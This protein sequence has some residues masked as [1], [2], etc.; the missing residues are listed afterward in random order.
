MFRS[1]LDE[2]GTVTRNKS[3][4]VAQGYHQEEGIDYDETFAPVARLEAIRLFLAYTAHK[5]FKV[6]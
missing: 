6:F 1:K 2:N 3:R 5:D 4:L